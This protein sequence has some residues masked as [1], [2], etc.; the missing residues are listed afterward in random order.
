MEISL[1]NPL[2]ALLP[3]TV[4]DALNLPSVLLLSLDD[5]RHSTAL[6]GHSLCAKHRQLL[7][8]T[9]LKETLPVSSEYL[10]TVCLLDFLLEN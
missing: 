7:G 5:P 9:K 2:S 8:D 4:T 3:G 10:L 1:W 6:S